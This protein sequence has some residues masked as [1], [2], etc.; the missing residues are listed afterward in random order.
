[1]FKTAVTLILLWYG[2]YG[3]SSLVVVGYY[4]F[5]IPYYC[6]IVF[7]E[8]VYIIYTMFNLKSKFQPP[9]NA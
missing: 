9:H 1:M 3:I 7:S 4:L 8:V 6:S 2:S 5:T